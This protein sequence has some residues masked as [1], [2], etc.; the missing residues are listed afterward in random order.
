MQEN[1]AISDWVPISGGSTEGLLGGWLAQRQAALRDVMAAG[2][3]PTFTLG[4]PCVPVLSRAAFV[5]QEENFW[6][7]LLIGHRPS[8]SNLNCKNTNAKKRENPVISDWVRISEGSTEGLLGG[9]LAQ[10]QAA[11]RDVMAAGA[12]PT[13]TLGL[14]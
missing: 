11:L 2:A 1:P 12:L 9:W 10:R 8:W 5:P 13:F 7:P 4:L 6:K 14:P 3:L